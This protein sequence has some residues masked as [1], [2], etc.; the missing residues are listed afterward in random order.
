MVDH[1]FSSGKLWPL[2]ELKVDVSQGG[3][4]LA[5]FQMHHRWLCH[6]PVLH[7]I[8]NCWNR[9]PRLFS[10]LTRKINEKK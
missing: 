7:L 10:S 5:D 8:V 4:T 6:S 9:L 2:E 1:T 3:E